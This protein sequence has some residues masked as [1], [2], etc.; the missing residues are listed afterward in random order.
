[1]G[2]LKK[3]TREGRVLRSGARGWFALSATDDND[4]KSRKSSTYVA[5]MQTSQI[6]DS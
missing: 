3:E 5:F 1:M 4:N 6:D 2:R